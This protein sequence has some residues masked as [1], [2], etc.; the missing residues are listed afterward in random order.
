MAISGAAWSEWVQEIPR[1]AVFESVVTC[2][3]F[4]ATKKDGTGSGLDDGHWRQ[5]LAG[6]AAKTRRNLPLTPV[7]FPRAV[8]LGRTMT[9]EEG[10]RTSGCEHDSF[11]PI[12][13]VHQIEHM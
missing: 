8:K 13:E 3:H 5:I 10:L 9:S 6:L 7:P 11:R 12:S 2:P 4:T 1:S